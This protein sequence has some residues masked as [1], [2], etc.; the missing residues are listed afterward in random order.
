MLKPPKANFLLLE[1]IR[2]SNKLFR[3]ESV[4]NDKKEL[5]LKSKTET[6]DTRVKGLSGQLQLK[7]KKLAACKEYI[8]GK[9]LSKFI[10][11]QELEKNKKIEKIKNKL[12]DIKKEY[13]E[14]KTQLKK[15]K[16]N[17]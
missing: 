16:G 2:R 6:Y 3:S 13:A 7:K 8:S 9:E 17:K 15:S 1:L 10:K 4:V 12:S 11:E 14:I 5:A